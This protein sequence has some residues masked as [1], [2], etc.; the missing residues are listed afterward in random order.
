VHSGVQ[1]G[2]WEEEDDAFNEHRRWSPSCEYIKSMFA[3]GIPISSENKPGTSSPREP[4]RS[5][6]VCG[7]YMEMNPI[8]VLRG[9]STFPYI[10]M[11]VIYSVS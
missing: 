6:D 5:N 8:L 7:P 9:V 10:S 4:A 1:V 3:G 11:F 2:C